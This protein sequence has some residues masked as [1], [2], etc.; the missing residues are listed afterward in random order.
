MC[1][2]GV[3]CAVCVGVCV[4]WV[5][6]VECACGVCDVVGCVHVGCGVC[7]CGLCGC[8]CVVYVCVCGVC[9]YNSVHC[10]FTSISPLLRPTDSIHIHMYINSTAPLTRCSTSFYSASPYQRQRLYQIQF[11]QLSGLCP[12]PSKPVS[13]KR[14]PK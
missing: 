14:L 4:V 12:G 6:C 2:C 7:V 10:H 5:W 3:W 9:V 13:L 8:V 1:A 11:R